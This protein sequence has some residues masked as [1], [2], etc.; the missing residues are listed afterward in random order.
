MIS[1]SKNI[2]IVYYPNYAGGKFV[3]NCLGFNTNFCPSIPLLRDH[4][5][6]FLSADQQLAHKINHIFAT[7]PPDKASCRQWGSYELQCGDFW[8]QN[9]EA[10][11]SHD[12]EL[13]LPEPAK[14]I[15]TDHHAFL[16][17]HTSE[18]L[19]QVKSRF[20]NAKVI[21]LVNYEKFRAHAVKLKMGSP[22]PRGKINDEISADFY[23]DMSTVFVWEKFFQQLKSCVE[24]F[25]H[26]TEFDQR[27]RNYYDQYVSLHQ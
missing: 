9:A 4:N 11:V 19:S 3:I 8:G 7:L 2:I 13:D 5:N 23:F 21:K 26:P 20:V 22:P 15:L 6:E 27:L 17:A 1:S 12:Q 24:C 25:G 10:L 16:I 14:Q 18:I